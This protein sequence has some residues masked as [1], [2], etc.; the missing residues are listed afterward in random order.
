MC[1]LG[2]GLGKKVVRQ[3][4]M[5]AIVLKIKITAKA[6]VFPS[7][8][9]Y[10]KHC[11]RYRSLIKSFNS[12]K[13]TTQ[14]MLLLPPFMVKKLNLSRKNNLTSGKGTTAV[15]R[16]HSRPYFELVCYLEINYRNY[17]YILC[18]STSLSISSFK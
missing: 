6:A 12:H 4:V 3:I 18:S 13:N 11:L 7:V 10:V 9:M 16:F 17:H 2:Y 1:I 14:S 15:G 8:L 5:I